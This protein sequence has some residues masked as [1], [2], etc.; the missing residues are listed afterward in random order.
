M[1]GR[2]IERIFLGD[3]L[4]LVE[5]ARQW[6][7]AHPAEST[8]LVIDSVSTQGLEA[9]TTFPGSE[10]VRI[11]T[12]ADAAEMLLPSMVS[13][14]PLI[15]RQSLWG[16]LKSISPEDRRRFFPAA[17]RDDDRTGWDAAVALVEE[18]FVELT[19]AGF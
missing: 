10:S 7:A 2:V 8:W 19:T 18:L 12:A 6:L 16:S 14:D 13:V 5:S 3:R 17:D 1:R 11:L 15:R 4:T 9:R